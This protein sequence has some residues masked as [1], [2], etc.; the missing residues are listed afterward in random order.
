MSRLVLA[1]KPKMAIL[2]GAVLL[3]A[4]QFF[5]PD[6]IER[7]RPDYNSAIQTTSAQ[8]VLANI[9]RVHDGKMPLVM[10]VTQINAALIVQGTLSPQ[11]SGI[12]TVMALASAGS[13]VTTGITPSTGATSG[14]LSSKVVSNKSGT[15]GGSLEYQESP[16][17]TYTP[18]SGQPLIAQLSTPITVDTLAALPDSNWPLSALTTLSVNYITPNYTDK[19]L[20][21]NALSE[22]DFDGV[23]TEAS[24]TSDLSSPPD[25]KDK[26]EKNVGQSPS[27]SPALQKNPGGTPND[28]LVFYLDRSFHLRS[29]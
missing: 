19:D 28:A 24:V 15:V 4:C 23:L 3:T 6:S 8:M 20:A 17:I 2:A 13:A 16:T 25:S 26:K 9:V 10:D 5:G 1:I 14:A 12:G 27:L 21:M 18:L 11:L 29:V 22:L 7:G